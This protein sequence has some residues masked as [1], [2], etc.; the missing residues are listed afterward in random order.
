M[1]SHSRER[2]S[3]AASDDAER[4]R[5]L[6][7][8]GIFAHI[9]AGKTTT[10]ERMLY[11]S[12]ALEGS[13]V[14]EV[15][16]GDTVMDFMDQERE[17]GITINSAATTFFWRGHQLN[18][19][20]TP[21]HVDFTVEVERAAR[22]LDGAVMIYDAVA[23]VQAQSETVWSQ[24]D[25]YGV[26]RVAFVNKMDRDGASLTRTAEAIRS[27]LGSEPLLMH[28]PLWHQGREGQAGAFRGVV[29]LPSLRMLLWD[30]DYTA[31][32]G[33][34]GRGDGHDFAD[35]SFAEWA[36]GEGEGEGDGE[37]GSSSTLFAGVDLG[38][39]R[40]EMRDMVLVAREVLAEVGC[41]HFGLSPLF[42]LLLSLLFSLF[43][44][45]FLLSTWY[46]LPLPL[47]LSL[48]PSLSPNPSTFTI[49]SRRLPTLTTLPPM[50]SWRTT[51]SSAKMR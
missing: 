3:S 41:V 28:L 20:D 17:R 40:A 29:D 19:I 10:T 18:L 32:T 7:N 26:P 27:R 14:G 5:L 37:G 23:G 45:S 15:H 48:S 9:D 43:L 49:A 16:D 11:F 1:T 25:R 8:I 12:G 51:V 50:P 47:S 39:S 34:A 38:C 30:Y 42:S 13:S 6:R 33:D 31:G 44:L 2:E 36:E 24:A 21:G 35:L 22:V 4:L 46:S